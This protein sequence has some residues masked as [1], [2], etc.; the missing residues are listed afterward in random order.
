MPA[1]PKL[2]STD[3]R[4]LGRVYFHIERIIM[5][6]YI[7]LLLI[8]LFGVFITSDILQF[9]L[10]HITPAIATTFLRLPWPHSK[11]PTEAEVQQR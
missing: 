7:T 5:F 2:A 8:I 4:L 1:T 11:N 9:S 3:F 6:V 10:Q